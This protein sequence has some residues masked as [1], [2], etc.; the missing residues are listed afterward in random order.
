MAVALSTPLLF[1]PIRSALLALSPAPGPCPLGLDGIPGVRAKKSW[2]FFEPSPAVIGS[3]TATNRAAGDHMTRG[4]LSSKKEWRLKL[5][6]SYQFVY[7]CWRGE[8]KGA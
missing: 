4:L 3:P 2:D 1:L 5:Q 8:R 7:S 6:I